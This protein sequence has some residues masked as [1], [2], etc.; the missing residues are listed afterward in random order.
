M[1]YMCCALHSAPFVFHITNDN[2][3][4]LVR[5]RPLISMRPLARLSTKFLR[6]CSAISNPLLRGQLL[7]EIRNYFF[8]F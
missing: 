8:V 6:H 5:N 3:G 2:K 4:F 7:L 1:I